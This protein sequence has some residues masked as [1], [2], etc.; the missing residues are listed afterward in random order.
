MA[1]LPNAQAASPL[2]NVM[3]YDDGHTA[4]PEDTTILQNIT[5]VI[6][7]FVDPSDLYNGTSNAYTPFIKTA[8]EKQDGLV[9]EGRGGNF[10]LLMEELRNELNSTGKGLSIAV[11]GRPEDVAVYSQYGSRIWK[12]VDFVNVMAYDLM[13]RRNNGTGHHASL[14]GANDTITEY[15]GKLGLDPGK[16]NLGFPF[17][18]KFF[19]LEK[20]ECSGPFGYEHCGRMCL[21]N[22]GDCHGNGIY[23][24]MVKSFQGAMDHGKFDEAEGAWWY[25]DTQHS[26]RN[27]FW[28]WDA[29]D[30]IEEKVTGIVN[31]R[32]LGGVMAWSLG[33]DSYDWARVKAMNAAITQ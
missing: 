26:P 27:F 14:T 13:N 32:G 28:A 9:E 3:Y 2:R 30:T 8:T 6:M 21:N 24:D 12:T 20:G 33:E 19:E 16:I 7:S 31:K 22:F 1:V 15:A 23:L 5:H 25:I 4:L 10:P 17:Y 11:P 18:A 29:P